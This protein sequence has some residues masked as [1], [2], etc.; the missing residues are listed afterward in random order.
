MDGDA[1]DQIRFYA[2]RAFAVLLVGLALWTLRYYATRPTAIDR[3]LERYASEGWRLDREHLVEYR[4][5]VRDTDGRELARR[6]AGSRR[7]HIECPEKLEHCTH[8]VV[9]VPSR[10]TIERGMEAVVGIASAAGTQEVEWK[11]VREIASG[12][13]KR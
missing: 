5:R 13:P 1:R 9:V 6:E 7:Y 11:L 3:Q 8:E 12:S 4:F 10:P 2:A